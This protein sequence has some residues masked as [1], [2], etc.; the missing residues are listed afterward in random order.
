MRIW[1]ALLVAPSLALACQSI[2][3]A[4]VT[5]SCSVQ[6][7]IGLHVAAFVALILAGASSALAHGEWRRRTHGSTTASD[8]DAPGPHT[9]GFLAAVALA[10]G[11]LSCLVI[12]TM[13]L[14]AW[15]LSPCWQ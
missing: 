12:L 11:L 9:R 6:T 8:T 4:L 15:I 13:W 7:R 1:L 10:V 3:F 5:P 2:M 14:A